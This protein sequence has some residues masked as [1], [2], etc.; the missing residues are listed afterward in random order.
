MIRASLAALLLAAAMTAATPAAGADSRSELPG[1]AAFPTPL[2][3]TLARVLAALA[4]ISGAG[5]GLAWWSRKRRGIGASSA[6]RIQV[7]ASRAIG[8]RHN[9]VLIEVGERRLLLGTAPESVRALADLSEIEPFA[10]QLARELP[11]SERTAR[12]ELVDGIG[13]FEG[14]DA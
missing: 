12:R 10:A 13:P 4:A 6:S 8:P 14:L 7:L 3:G 11:E 1:V 9:V 2:A 5:A